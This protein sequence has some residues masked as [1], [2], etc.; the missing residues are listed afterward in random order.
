MIRPGKTIVMAIVWVLLALY[1]VPLGFKWG[2]ERVYVAPGKGLIV[3]NKFG[4]AL[5]ADLIVAPRDDN[6]YKGVQEEVRGPGRYF[7]NP[8]EYDWKEVPLVEVSAG[9]PES[10]DWDS[11]GRLKDPSTLPKLGLVAAKGGKTP[12]PGT[13]VVDEGFKGLQKRILTPGTYKINPQQYEV[14]LVDAVVVPPG[15]VGVVTRL[16]GDTGEIESRPFIATPTTMGTEASRLVAG[17]RQRGVLRDV[18]QPGIYYIN[19]RIAK[20]TPVT[21]GYDAVTLNHDSNTGIIFYSSDG[22][23]VEADFTVVWGRTPQDAPHIVATIGNVETVR[24]NIIEPAMKAACQNI[25]AG[26]TAKQLIQGTSRE[27]AQA[28]LSENLKAQVRSRHV[29]V[30]L[31]LIRN[32]AIRDSSGKDA[33]MGLLAT[34]Q[35]ANIEV[36][37]E[38]TN[39][40][41]TQTAIVK[42]R[43]E[44]A[45][46]L[47]D[48][49]RETVASETLVR[50]A[51][52]QADSQKKAAEIDAQRELDVSAI[53]L[54]VAQL[55]AQRTTI[56]GKAA[57]EVSRL[58]NDAE[59]KGAKMLIDAFG[60]AQAYNLFTFAK[61]FDPQ[62]LRLIFAGPG[63]FWTDLKTFEQ[64]GAARLL[65]PSP[66]GREKK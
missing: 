7:L 45:T 21:V 26:Y 57:A 42:A 58:K 65:Q 2:V 52:I 54:Q 4:K 33:T 49:A 25:G 24:Q 22:Y 32:I 43:L 34:I 48:V 50:V 59:A 37:R 10:W 62:E 36:E 55:D 13:E 29:D 15:S 61:N 31:A 3:I 66:D 27:E 14:T 51:N 8:I 44:Q 12:P 18:L 19:P 17:P 64:A 1:F 46:K 5:P 6:S 35:Q 30:L 11:N 20:V 38:L 63:T 23:L 60:S 16:I 40:Q 39:Q 53:Q 41:K 9:S 28:A 56:M 47:V